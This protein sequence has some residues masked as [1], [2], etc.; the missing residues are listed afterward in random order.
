VS[1]CSK[2]AE[3]TNFK[4]GRRVLR[5]SPVISLTNVSKKWAWSRS[6]DPVNFGVLNAYSSK[7][8]KGTNF[9]FGTC[10]PRDRT[11][12]THAKASD[13]WAWPGSRDPINF[14]AL[15]ANSSKTAEGMNFKFGRR[16]LRDSINQSINLYCK[17]T[18]DRMQLRN[19][20]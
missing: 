15:N 9:K 16:V 8:A 1:V 10:V 7:M 14:W 2:T 20:M 11:D 19:Q 17:N 18:A 13:M 3:G 6:R 12:M 4:F 5:D